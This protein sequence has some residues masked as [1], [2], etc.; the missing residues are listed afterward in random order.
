MAA[1][2]YGRWLT[3]GSGDI[4]SGGQSHVY[5]VTDS[6]G[7]Y[8]GEY[9]LKR[10]IN[11][12]RIDRFSQELRAVSALNHQSIIKI[13]DSDLESDRPFIVMPLY[14]RGSLD[15]LNITSEPIERRVKWFLEVFDAIEHA[16]ANGVIHRDIK[17]SNVLISE[18]GS[19]V[20]C[21]FGI[22]YVE[23][24]EAKTMS[25]E[26]VGSRSFSS[27]EM[28]SGTWQDGD[29]SC[30]VYSLGKLLYWLLSGKILPRE[31]HGEDDW[32]I[33]RVSDDQ[34]TRWF[35]PLFN[36]MI[37]PSRTGRFANASTASVFVRQACRKFDRII[38]LPGHKSRQKCIYC[39]VG[40]YEAT[41]RVMSDG[42]LSPDALAK[43]V[44]L[45][46]ADGTKFLSLACNR[47][48]NI[49]IFRLDHLGHKN[50][51]ADGDYP[52]LY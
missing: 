5:R 29:M 15:K 13:I 6:Q 37:T 16:H 27:P 26:I 18:D 48:G 33:T 30:D 36:Q 24:G 14:S 40:R 4:G 34:R 12:K 50:P 22:C 25:G 31:R 2:A 38:N 19:A 28:E 7:Q 52:Y 51:W 9:A 8:V 35:E 39:G 44:G 20:V 21:D 49:Q 17:P 43:G 3:D 47:C 41:G 11:K 32:L 10:L 46:A 42:S 45:K 23:G 1:K